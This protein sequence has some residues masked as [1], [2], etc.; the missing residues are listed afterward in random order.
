M[1]SR[2]LTWLRSLLR[3]TEPPLVTDHRPP[4]TF[5]G[6]VVGRIE[7]ATATDEGLE[8]KFRLTDPERFQSIAGPMSLSLAPAGTVPIPQVSDW[9]E[10]LAQELADA[11]LA[12]EPG[13]V[14]GML[15][16][17]TAD[18]QIAYEVLVALSVTVAAVLRPTGHDGGPIGTP[19][20]G[21]PADPLWLQAAQLV[22]FAAQ[23]DVAMVDAL[24]RAIV[25]RPEAG[26]PG[27]LEARSTLWAILEVLASEPISPDPQENPS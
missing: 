6:E 3:G 14:S 23:R 2:I 13:D 1:K 25:R 24:A 9:A 12:D 19:P 5:G 15:T 11:R 7:S 18:A 22:G 8:V 20:I 4:V 10:L 21:T 17:A 16:A 26:Y 27:V